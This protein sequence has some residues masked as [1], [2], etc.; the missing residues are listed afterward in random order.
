VKKHPVPAKR[1]P[2]GKPIDSRACAVAPSGSAVAERPPEVLEASGPGAFLAFRYT[3]AEISCSGT[4]AR[5]RAKR[6]AY[7]GGRL[8]SESFEGELDREAC[9]RISREA[10]RRFADQTALFL[11]SFFPFL[12]LSRE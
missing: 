5:V 2:V 3:Y 1:K 7:E 10:Q 9:E 12:P 4:T 6:A 8:V 11:R